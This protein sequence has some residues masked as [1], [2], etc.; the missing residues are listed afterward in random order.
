MARTTRTN[1]KFWQLSAIMAAQALALGLMIFAGSIGIA[2]E[3]ATE[4]AVAE[5]ATPAEG[6]VAAEKASPDAEP[7]RQRSGSGVSLDLS[8]S[9]SR[10]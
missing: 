1:R 2:D 4:A 3:A 9:L 7:T 5:C 10:G 6:A 8:I